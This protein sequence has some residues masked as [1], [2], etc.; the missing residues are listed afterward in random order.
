MKDGDGR[1][2]AQ[3]IELKNT[4]RIHDYFRILTYIMV[5]ERQSYISMGTLERRLFAAISRCREL[6]HICDRLFATIAFKRW[7][8]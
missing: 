2:F 7:M 6:V 1:P 4:Q 8:L 5:S 3:P